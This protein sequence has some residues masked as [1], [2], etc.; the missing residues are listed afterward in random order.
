[1]PEGYYIESAGDR[2]VAFMI[3]DGK[4]VRT[5]IDAGTYRTVSGIHIGSTETETQA[6]YHRRLRVEPHHYD[7][8]GHYLILGS[9]DMKSALLL[10]TDGKKVTSMRAGAEPSVEYVE[11]CL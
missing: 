9:A 4:V 5:D 11:G 8:N 10:E 1:M 2:G 7:D 3:E 6:A